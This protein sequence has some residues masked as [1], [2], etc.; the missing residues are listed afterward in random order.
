MVKGGGTPI[1][2]ELLQAYFQNPLV[3][4]AYTIAMIASISTSLT[5]LLHS[6]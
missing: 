3:W 1:S 6:L 2:F 4:G 5:V